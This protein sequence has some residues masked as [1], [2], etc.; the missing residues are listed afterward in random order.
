MTPGQRY[1]LLLRREYQTLIRIAEVNVANARYSLDTY[2]HDDD[3]I[4]RMEQMIRE[5]EAD[6]VYFREKLAEM[7]GAENEEPIL[8]ESQ[9]G[10]E[11]PND[12]MERITCTTVL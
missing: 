4:R 12:K 3:S 2:V 9:L 6:I 7:G 5:E 8:T 10:S 1:L 11:S